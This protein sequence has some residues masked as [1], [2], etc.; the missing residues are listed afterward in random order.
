[1]A[2]PPLAPIVR[3]IVR[4]PAV[5]ESRGIAIEPVP[6]VRHWIGRLTETIANEKQRRV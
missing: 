1:M 5:A 4:P 6:R 2:K 3:S